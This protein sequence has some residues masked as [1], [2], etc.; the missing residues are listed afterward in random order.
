M[1]FAGHMCPTISCDTLLSV[2]HRRVQE[3]FEPTRETRIATHPKGPLSIR[4]NYAAKSSTLLSL[5]Q[6]AL[7]IIC[8]GTPQT[9]NSTP[10][11]LNNPIIVVSVF[12]PIVPI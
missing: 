4:R 8:V 2:R 6:N 5:S 11:T 3:F 9:L 12:F 7:Y 10:Q 1:I